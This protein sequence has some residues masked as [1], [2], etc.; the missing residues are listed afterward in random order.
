MGACSSQS[1]AD[2]KAQEEKFAEKPQANVFLTRLFDCFKTLDSDKAN[3]TANLLVTL[4]SDNY[5]PNCTFAGSIFY[6]RNVTRFEHYHSIAKDYVRFHKDDYDDYYKSKSIYVDGVKPYLLAYFLGQFDKAWINV[7][8]TL[9]LRSNIDIRNDKIFGVSFY[10][11]FLETVTGK[12][13]E[14]YI[15]LNHS[16]IKKVLNGVV[17]DSAKSM[18]RFIDKDEVELIKDVFEVC[19][20]KELL[21]KNNF[22]FNIVTHKG[23]RS[24]L[25]PLFV[26]QGQDIMWRRGLDNKSIPEMAVYCRKSADYLHLVRNHDVLKACPTGLLQD[27]YY[28]QLTIECFTETLK[29]AKEAKTDIVNQKDKNGLTPSAFVCLG[30][31]K[32]SHYDDHE[33]TQRWTDSIIKALIMEGADIYEKVNGKRIV[34]QLFEWDYPKLVSQMIQWREEYIKSISPPAPP[35]VLGV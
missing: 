9:Y 25:I 5:D 4:Y 30:T 34:D 24:H 10:D 2:K 16:W 33:S 13:T 23:D 8:A 6:D 32:Y 35:P 15:Y 11:L 17:F 22:L 18:S 29:K 3:D 14:G 21:Q 1:K 28:N 7:Y 20:C 26:S 19:D 31:T 12:G 27:L